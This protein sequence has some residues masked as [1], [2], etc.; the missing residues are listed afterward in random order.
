MVGPWTQIWSSAAAWARMPPC[1]KAAAQT[2]QIG[3]D[4]WHCGPWIPAQP[5]RV[6]Q[7][8]DL[9]MA[10]SGNKSHRCQHRPPWLLQILAQELG[11]WQQPRSRHHLGL[12][13]IDV[14]LFLT[15]LSSSDLPL[16]QPIN[17]STFS[18]IFPTLYSLSIMVPNHTALGL[19]VGSQVA[20]NPAC[21][22]LKA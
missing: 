1:A 5:Q 10:F 7:T 19:L 20:C 3:M 14:S 22:S 4:L 15:T 11:R 21:T 6:T 2:T 16:L 17:H 8:T 9:C 18:Y 13:S 12:R